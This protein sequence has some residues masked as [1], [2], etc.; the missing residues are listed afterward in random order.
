MRR[1]NY[2]TTFMAEGLVIGSYLLAFRLVAL[3]SGP[4]GFGEY[5]LSRRTLSLLMPVAVVGVDLG[6]ARYVSYAQADK[7]GKSPGYVAAG[8][9]VLAAG[10]G[11]V[12]A[13]LLVAPGFWGEVFFG[14]SSY[15]SLVLALPPLLAGGGL[16]VIAFG[17][18][19]GLNRIQAAN[20]LMAINM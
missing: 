2:L 8:L 20:V 9:I 1:L 5:S 13:I 3:F 4:Q 17:Y 12:S 15:G 11:I 14:S 6:V 19:R 18:L 16:H 7:S 10:V